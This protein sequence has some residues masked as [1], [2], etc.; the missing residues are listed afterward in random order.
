MSVMPPAFMSKERGETTSVLKPTMVII[1]KIL[2][3]TVMVFA[4]MIVVMIPLVIVASS[5]QD[6][7]S[8]EELIETPHSW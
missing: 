7:L 1:G 3:L 8:I 2:L 4:L 6:G 5:L